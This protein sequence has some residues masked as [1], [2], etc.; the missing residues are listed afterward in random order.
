MVGDSN[1]IMFDSDFGP[2]VVHSVANNRRNLPSR[3]KRHLRK[4]FDSF[5]VFFGGEFWRVVLKR[6]E[7]RRNRKVSVGSDPTP[8]ATTDDQKRAVGQ[9]WDSWGKIVA[10][11]G[12]SV[13][14]KN[15][16]ADRYFRNQICRYS[17]V[18]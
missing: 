7:N 12:E 4:G 15:H 16:Y 5:T 8:S 6:L 9:L 18:V 13:I 17:I 1:G 2:L 3:T 14:S 10:I 11:E